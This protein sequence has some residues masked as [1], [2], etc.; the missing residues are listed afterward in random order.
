MLGED[1]PILWMA[2]MELVRKVET[3]EGWYLPQ[4]SYMPE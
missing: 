3:I 2:M 4:Y 1:G